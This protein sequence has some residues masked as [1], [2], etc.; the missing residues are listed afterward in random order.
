[1]RE[2]WLPAKVA[3]LGGAGAPRSLAKQAL[4]GHGVHISIVHAYIRQALPELIIC[5]GG[6]SAQ[7]GH[8]FFALLPKVVICN[9]FAW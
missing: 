1:M 7:H 4:S 8:L 6:K 9:P 5:N 2:K 3:G